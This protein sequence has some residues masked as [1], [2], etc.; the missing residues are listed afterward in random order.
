MFKC[1]TRYHDECFNE[2]TD[3]KKIDFQLTEFSA[4]DVPAPFSSAPF[5]K[6]TPVQPQMD[7]MNA[8]TGIFKS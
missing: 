2:T 3:P 5:F 7:G 6:A 4:V 1:D 8:D